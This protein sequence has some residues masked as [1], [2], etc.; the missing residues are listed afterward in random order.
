LTAACFVWTVRGLVGVLGL[1]C[2]RRVPR[3]GFSSG[4]H[5]LC[6]WL[7]GGVHCSG[8]ARTPLDA[9][10]WHQ[11]FGPLFRAPPNNPKPPQYKIIA[12]IIPAPESY[13]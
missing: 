2:S 11:G 4:V 3:V 13:G 7:E 12:K 6:P 1:S 5:G 10:V 9:A 8:F